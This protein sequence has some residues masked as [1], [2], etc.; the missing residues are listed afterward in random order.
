MRA[1]VRAASEKDESLKVLRY[2][3]RSCNIRQECIVKHTNRQ[4]L[5][6]RK[7]TIASKKMGKTMT[8]WT[9]VLTIVCL[10]THNTHNTNT[11][12]LDS[13]WSTMEG[14]FRGPYTEPRITHDQRWVKSHEAP[15]TK[16][17]L[18]FLEGDWFERDDTYLQMPLAR[19]NWTNKH[20]SQ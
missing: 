3:L 18:S 14:W 2:D 17:L 5:S 6:S 15:K 10:T 19:P 8:V 11:P 12:T 20:K 9:I 7:Q 13:R 16:E 1:Q 4:P